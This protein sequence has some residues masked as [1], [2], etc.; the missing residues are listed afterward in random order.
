MEGVKIVPKQPDPASR[1]G[2]S[3]KGLNADT[4]APSPPKTRL[5]PRRGPQTLLRHL[6]RAPPRLPRAR[7]AALGAKT[8]RQPIDT[9]SNG[10]VRHRRRRAAA[11][12]ERVA[13]PSP[14]RLPPPSGPPPCANRT[15]RSSLAP[16][17][18]RRPTTPR[19][20]GRDRARPLRSPVTPPA[21]S[22][23]A[24][25]SREQRGWTGSAPVEDVR[26]RRSV[27]G[28]AAARRRASQR[29]TRRSR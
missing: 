17:R 4:N 5:T 2:G 11:H 21:P 13:D 14:V 7:R 12:L 3:G 18:P 8:D 15:F 23:V 26:H 9:A 28:A 20:G 19:S 29:C 27:D 25:V 24:D 10:R 6:P 16:R 22:S 1:A